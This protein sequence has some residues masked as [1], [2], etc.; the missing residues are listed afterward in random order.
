MIT[1]P[2]ALLAELTYRCP[3]RCGYC[4]N[5]T[6]IGR[7]TPELST[8]VWQ[9]VLR[10]AGEMGVL[11][12]HFSGGEPLLRDDLEVL[13]DTARSAGLYVNL[14]TSAWGLTEARTHELARVGVDHVQVS[15]Q[16]SDAQRADRVAGV[17]VH[18]QKVMAARW[19]REAGMSLSV[20]AVL[21]RHNLE[22]V[23]EIIALA[24]SF[25][26]ER[27]E[28][29][30]TQYHGSA[31]ENRRGLMPSKR[32]LDRAGEIAKVEQERLRGVMD[33][34]WVIPDLYADLPRPCMDGW[35]QR[36]MTISPD[37]T[38]LPCPGAHDLPGMALESVR[39][40]SVYELWAHG[41]D[42]ERFRGTHWM[43]EPCVSCDRREIDFG[44]CRCQAMTLAGDPGRTDP[45][46]A[47]SPD[48][49]VVLALRR[50]A[51]ESDNGVSPVLYRITH[52][53]R[54]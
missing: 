41:R 36:F 17:D 45:A 31:W 46:C 9:R 10:E 25:G 11:H 54:G 53:R 15:V 24:E 18:A 3:L 38:A 49:D 4:S 51:A 22:R 8:E 7:F 26:A 29:A 52:R 14:I 20:N 6:A 34:L 43:P 30:N 33:I 47:K 2:D 12:A 50:E 40:R 1:P 21:H 37:G 23:G 39:D 13:V 28:L 5:P 19:V 35:G 27:L 16:D 44:G 32:Q 48:H 42:F